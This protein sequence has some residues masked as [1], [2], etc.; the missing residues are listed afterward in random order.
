M[1][2]KCHLLQL[3]FQALVTLRFSQGHLAALSLPLGY[4]SEAFPLSRKGGKDWAQK[5]EDP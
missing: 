1:P 3:K 5:T 4:V 2:H